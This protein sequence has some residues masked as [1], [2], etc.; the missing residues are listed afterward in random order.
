MFSF[1]A[2]FLW[3]LFIL[4]FLIITR[5]RN[6]FNIFFKTEILGNDIEKYINSSENKNKDIL[7]W[8][9]KEFRIIVNFSYNLYSW[10]FS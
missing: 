10:I 9:K 6:N 4:L 5:K 8:A 1:L 2:L 3:F 7:P